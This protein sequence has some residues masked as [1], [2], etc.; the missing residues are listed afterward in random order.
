MNTESILQINRAYK[1]HNDLHRIIVTNN[2]S[3]LL[4]DLDESKYQSAFA[5]I[6][7]PLVAYGL[8]LFNGQRTV[9]DVYRLLN[10][11]NQCSIEKFCELINRITD[12]TDNVYMSLSFG[13]VEIP[14]FFLN[15]YDGKGYRD[16]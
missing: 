6:M 9:S 2:N 12:N 14:R 3:L 7:H 4:R 11:E 13:K 8:S 10:I 16:V 1:F 5:W 15:Q